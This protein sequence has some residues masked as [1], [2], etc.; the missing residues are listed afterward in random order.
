MSTKHLKTILFL[1]I[2][3]LGFLIFGFFGTR[4]R[5]TAV[6]LQP[7]SETLTERSLPVSARRRSTTPQE[8]LKDFQ[9]TD[10][11]R[12]LIDNN[13]RTTAR[14]I[15]T[16]RIGETL[17]KDTTLTDIQPKQVTLEKAGVL[18]T[19]LLNTTPLLK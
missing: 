1:S 16:V 13:L 18:R 17:D 14:T 11:Y 10:F 9:K 6:S 15:Y 3:V 12:T 7:K 5:Q 4:S 2:G 8:T 19:L